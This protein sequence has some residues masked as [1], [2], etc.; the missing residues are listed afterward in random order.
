MDV[1]IEHIDDWKKQM[2]VCVNWETVS[3]D[4]KELLARYAALPLKGFRAGKAPV[5]IVETVYRNQLRDDLAAGTGRRLCRTALRD[6]DLETASPLEL[7]EVEMQKGE[8]FSFCADFLVVPPFDLP[9]YT[10]LG[11]AATDDAQ[12]LDE[13]S[14]RLLHLTELV[15]HESLV[16]KELLY[17]DGLPGEASEQELE[18][19]AQRVKLMLTLKKI[20]LREGIEI[21]ERDI[22][23][24]IGEVARENGVTEEE[25]RAYLD[26]SGGMERFAD[27]LLAEQVL[28]FLAETQR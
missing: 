8:N 11:I 17:G 4:Y 21:D 23:E 5:G 6:N 24:R 12:R 26:M 1:K 14:E 3:G 27:T 2:R 20:A 9:D 16:E 25:L 28:G 7:S 19:A 22:T 10:H 18:A 13:I 15:P